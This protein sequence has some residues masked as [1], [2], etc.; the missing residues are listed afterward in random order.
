MCLAALLVF[1]SVV[2]CCQWH[3][4]KRQLQALLEDLLFSYLCLPLK[5]AADLCKQTLL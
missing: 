1:V 3:Q 4:H 2:C 5:Q